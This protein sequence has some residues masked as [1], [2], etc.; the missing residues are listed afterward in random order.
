[1][2]NKHAWA[3][4]MYDG[5][6]LACSQYKDLRQRNGEALMLAERRLHPSFDPHLAKGL[7]RLSVGRIGSEYGTVQSARA[8]YA[9]MVP[10]FGW[11]GVPKIQAKRKECSVAG[12]TAGSGIKYNP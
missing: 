10:R 6:G 11:S 8:C 3:W 9:V 1:M 5:C 12:H 7:A 4:L 2:R